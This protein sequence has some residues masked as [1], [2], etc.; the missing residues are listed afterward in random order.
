V[1]ERFSMNLLYIFTSS[2]FVLR[3]KNCLFLP[4]DA[5]LARYA[6]C[7]SATNRSSIETAGRIELVLAWEIIPAPISLCVIRNS[8]RLPARIR[9]LSC[10]TLSQTV[11]LDNFAM[12]CRWCCQQNSTTVEL[13][14][15]SYDGRRVVTRAHITRWWTVNF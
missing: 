3:S 11:D 6:M 14:D 10:G 12:S 9:V 13:M 8:V 7:P 4:R 5:V 1:R 2:G 15:H